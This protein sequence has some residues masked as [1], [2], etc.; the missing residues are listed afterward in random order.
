MTAPAIRNK[1]VDLL[2]EAE[3]ADDLKAVALLAIAD[4]YMMLLQFLPS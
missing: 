2:K 4:R 1:I 3:T